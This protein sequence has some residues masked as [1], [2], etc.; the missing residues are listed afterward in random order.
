[1]DK[2]SVII[3]DTDLFIH[4]WVA[5][6]NGITLQQASEIHKSN[7][8][9][10]QQA[11]D[12]W[13]SQG[14]TIKYAIVEAD[15]ADANSLISTND[16]SDINV[17]ENEYLSLKYFDF[18][19]PRPDWFSVWANDTSEY[20]DTNNFTVSQD[21]RIVYVSVIDNETDEQV[22]DYLYVSPNDSID[23][24]IY[25]DSYKSSNYVVV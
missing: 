4:T 12:Y 21:N 11:F 14:G 9:S 18:S 6:P 20:A 3:T 8:F 15:Y 5:L 19:Q 7:N 23:N 25:E 24:G 22:S 10:S 17:L 13:V 1:M 16:V 2:Y